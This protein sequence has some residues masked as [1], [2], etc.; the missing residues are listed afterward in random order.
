LQLVQ[1]GVDFLVLG[2]ITDIENEVDWDLFS[3]YLDHPLQQLS[4]LQL[5]G[6]HL[7]TL[8]TLNNFHLQLAEDVLN[9]RG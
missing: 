5:L 6:N 8:L 2:V 9:L 1:V 3:T 7:Q 4:P